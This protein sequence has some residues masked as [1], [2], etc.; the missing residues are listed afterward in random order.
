MEKE[1]LQNIS[2]ILNTKNSQMEVLAFLQGFPHM[3]W[4]S[5][6]V[7]KVLFYFFCSLAT[8][9]ISA[10]VQQELSRRKQPLYWKIIAFLTT[11]IPFYILEKSFIGHCIF[12]VIFSGLCLSSLFFPF[13]GGGE[14]I[15]ETGQGFWRPFG[16]NISLLILGMSLIF[17]MLRPS[18][19]RAGCSLMCITFFR[20]IAHVLCFY[21]ILKNLIFNKMAQK[22]WRILWRF[23]PVII[24]IPVLLLL[25]VIALYKIKLIF[26]LT[27]F[28]FF[29]FF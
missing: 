29:S 2:G 3:D 24:G 21:I 20:A 12:L 15:K 19:A 8:V 10:L 4:Q 11:G 23:F 13:F 6:L 16:Q 7:I 26:N 1:V 22:S 14:N 25:F 9:L 27:N 17:S 5:P 28:H 18:L